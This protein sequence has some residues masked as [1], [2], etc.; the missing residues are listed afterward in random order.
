MIIVLFSFIYLIVG[1]FCVGLLAKF[2]GYD[3]NPICK[4]EDIGVR[5]VLICIWPFII[6]M[7]F[8]K[9]LGELTYTIQKYMEKQNKNEK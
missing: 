5:I 4:D 2:L 3:S 6:F 1:C 9:Y 8:F 7:L